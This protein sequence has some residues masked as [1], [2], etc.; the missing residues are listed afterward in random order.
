M[1]VIKHTDPVPDPRA[2]NQ[3]KKNMLFSVSTLLSFS[4]T[5]VG[6]SLLPWFELALL[7]LKDKISELKDV[8][9]HLML[10]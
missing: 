5:I 8:K 2:V 6:K 9:A 3:D 1:S 7:E 4:K 10:K